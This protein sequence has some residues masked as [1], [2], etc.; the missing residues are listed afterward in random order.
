MQAEYFDKIIKNKLFEL[1][2]KQEKNT[3]LDIR[4]SLYDQLKSVIG[5]YSEFDP[6]DFEELLNIL[7]DPKNE[8]F[9][10]NFNILSEINKELNSVNNYIEAKN[11]IDKIKL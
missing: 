5:S 1:Y 4:D 3:H 9:E 2:N 11:I 8:Y 10:K 7:R 6:D